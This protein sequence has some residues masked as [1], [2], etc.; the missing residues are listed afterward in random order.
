[1]YWEMLWFLETAC[2]LVACIVFWSLD[3]GILMVMLRSVWLRKLLVL[4]FFIQYSTKKHLYLKYVTY[5]HAELAF[6]L[7]G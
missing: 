3:I 4:D 5:S 7:G 1:M 6:R 2:T